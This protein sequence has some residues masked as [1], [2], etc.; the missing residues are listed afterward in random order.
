MSV[1]NVLSVRQ[2]VFSDPD[3]DIRE[4]CSYLAGCL[5]QARNGDLSPVDGDEIVGALAVYNGGHLYPPKDKWW[6][7]W[8]G[9]IDAYKRSLEQA[10]EMLD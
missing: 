6:D 5:A 1:E 8:R 4:M 2:L 3:R 10:K 7:I 9:N